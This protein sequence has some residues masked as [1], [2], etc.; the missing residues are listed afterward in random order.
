MKFIF[1]V[2][3]SIMLNLSAKDITIKADKYYNIKIPSNWINIPKY[4]LK[5]L[6]NNILKTTG[7][8]SVYNYG[9]QTTEVKRWFEYPYVLIRVSVKGKIN[10]KSLTNYKKIKSGINDGL[11]IAKNKVKDSISNASIGKILY[12]PENHILWSK[13]NIDAKEDVK[14]QVITAIKL[15]EYGFIQFN[16]YSFK[17]DMYKYEPIFK[18]MIYNI[19]LKEKDIYKLK[20]DYLIQNQL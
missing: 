19:K 8:V 11:N 12:E 15:T 10:E 16:G 1:L 17:K 3:F 20:K 18:R 6:E 9:Y 7:V 5:E 2:L 4:K 13:I 14:L